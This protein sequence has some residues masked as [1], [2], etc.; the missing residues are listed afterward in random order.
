MATAND[1]LDGKRRPPTTTNRRGISPGPTELVVPNLN[2][3][4]VV[5]EEE[6]HPKMEEKA[7]KGEMDGDVEVK[8]SSSSS[9]VESFSGKRFTHG[10]NKNMTMCDIE[11]ER[12]RSLSKYERNMMIFNWLH[13]LVLPL[14]L[15]EPPAV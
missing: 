13:S 2:A 1:Q 9:A 12:G 6:Q 3:P 5:T 8:P 14:P 7:L 11:L 4:Q 15:E 10:L